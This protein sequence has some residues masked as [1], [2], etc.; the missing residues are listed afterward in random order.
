[1]HKSKDFY[2]RVFGDYALWTAPETKGGGEKT[3]YQVI[4]RQAAT[5]IVDA[6]YFK[7]VFINVVDEVKVIKPIQSHTMGYRALY[8]N[9]SLGLNY[10]TPLVDVEYLI[11]YHFEWNMDRDEYANDRNFKKHEAIMDRSLEKGGRRDIFL[12]AREFVGY[13]EKISE[14]DYNF[15]KDKDFYYKNRTIA[16]GLM[17]HSFKYPKESGGKLISYYANTVMKNGTIKFKSQDECEV[18][19]ILSDYSFKYPIQKKS[20]D[21]ELREYGLEEQ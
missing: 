5:G 17:F 9:G 12:G 7:P 16:F 11:K 6:C 3:S 10:V 21:V 19:N 20:V 1:M 13:I 18:K 2:M 4:T 15:P 8:G 14:E